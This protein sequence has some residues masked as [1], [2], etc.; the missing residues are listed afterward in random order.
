MTLIMGRVK[1]GKIYIFG[2]T[3]LTYYSKDRA[4]PFVEGC[5]KQ[6]IINENLAI[7]FSGTREH[8]ES[9]CDRYLKCNDSNEI[10]EIALTS[11]ST[12][13]KYDLL[14]GEVG[15]G[16]I[17][18]VRNCK[19]YEAEA[20]YLGDRNAFNAFQKLYHTSSDNPFSPVEQG[21]AMIHFLQVP[22][23]ILEDE[24]FH[25][26][27]KCFKQVIC[28]DKIKG[29]G[30]VIVPVCTNKGK[31]QYMTYADVVSDVLK[32]EEFRD[33][34]KQIK[35]GTASGGGYSVDFCNDAPYGGQGREVG[36]YFLQGGFGVVF[37]RNEKGFRNA[38]IIKAKNPAYWVLETSKKFE[39]GITSIYL[40]EDHCG[41]AGEELLRKKR[42]RDA[43]FCYELKKNLKT[44]I[45]RPKVRDRYIAG[46]ATALFNSGKILVAL[47]TLKSEIRENVN[48]PRCNEMLKKMLNEVSGGN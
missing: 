14:I 15:Y 16:K 34:P 23:P 2:D 22:E 39:H 46:Y 28:D 21:R 24:I 35:F 44:L 12:G 37:P 26:L 18:F 5:L 36:Y 29:V 47:N 10:I 11:Q 4:N 41:I 13:L 32:I 48:S 20:G 17:R 8:F 31:F 42:F 9:D 19:I 45:N 40:T 6:Y 25:R 7:A 3:E 30:G 38:E 27:Y 33:E 43:L 1:S